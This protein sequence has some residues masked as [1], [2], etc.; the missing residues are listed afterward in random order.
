M[1]QIIFG[2]SG[3]SRTDKLISMIGDRVGSRRCLMIVPDQYTVTTERLLLEKLGAQSSLWAE[4]VG[5]GRL[6]DFVF[7]R[8]GGRDM[9]HL[10]E[11]GARILLSGVLGAVN[12]DLIYY[13]EMAKR[14]GFVEEMLSQIRELAANKVS[15]DKLHAAAADLADVNL[16]AKLNDLA[17]ISEAYRAAAVQSVRGYEFALDGAVE[18][19][20]ADNI[21]LQYDIFIDHFKRFTAQEYEMLEVMI[22]GGSYVVAG[23]TGEND[24]RCKS[25]LDVFYLPYKTA[26][27]LKEIAHGCGQ[28]IS[29]DISVP[30]LGI[31]CEDIATFEKELFADVV[32][33]LEKTAEHIKIV[34]AK[35]EY[36]ELEFI[37]SEIK[38]LAATNGYRWRDFAVVTRHSRMT[39]GL[40]E[41]AFNRYDIPVQLDTKVKLSTLPLMT[42]ILSAFDSVRSG[43]TYQNVFRYLKTGL[44]GLLSYQVDALEKYCYAWKIRGSAW[45]RP[46]TLHPDG[47]NATPTRRSKA[48][49]RLLNMW[50]NRFIAPLQDFEKQ[51]KKGGATDISKAVY[52]LLI[53][54]K[55]TSRLEEVS[56]LMPPDK[57][58]LYSQV[59]D[60][61]M[62]ILDDMTEMAGAAVMPERY[63]ELLM[64]AG[65]HT[66]IGLI[67]AT[68]DQVL[69]SEAERVI[70]ASV[71]CTFVAGFVS[72][73][74]PAVQGQNSLLTI[75][76][77][78]EL[79]TQNLKLS[80]VALAVEPEERYLAYNALTSATKLLYITMPE[81]TLAGEA[82]H[83]SIYLSPILKILPKN[84]IQNA[85]K[86]LDE[87]GPACE[88][89]LVEMLLCGGG[90]PKGSA[91]PE[92]KIAENFEAL[93]SKT[94][95]MQQIPNASK[96]YDGKSKL[97]A[98]SG[99]KYAKCNFSYFCSNGLR[100]QPTTQN[101]FGPMQI[102]T[103]I[104]YVLEQF[105][106]RVPKEGRGT[107]SK[108]DMGTVIE[109][110]ISNYM[111]EY[112]SKDE[113]ESARFTYLFGRLY[114]IVENYM[115]I[116]QDELKNSEFE[117]LNFELNVG[118]DIPPI[119]YYDDSGKEIVI[120]GVID[121]VDGY[122]KD[123]KLYLRIVDYKTG[124]KKIN[125]SELYQGIGL[126]MFLYLAA[127]LKEGE[128]FY[129]EPVYPAGVVYVPVRLDVI[130]GTSRNISDEELQKLRK[131]EIEKNALLINDEEI[132][133]AM[134]K[135]GKFL[136]LPVSTD[137]NGN[138]KL[139][140]ASAAS[141]EQLMQLADFAGR[142]LQDTAGKI[143]EGYV[144]VNPQT[145]STDK[146]DACYFCDMRPVCK[147]EGKGIKMPTVSKDEFWQKIGGNQNG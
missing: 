129:G 81:S 32:I 76:E 69:I 60:A 20:T 97:S 31:F 142:V 1:L 51:I 120:K 23:L 85:L 63:S 83:K 109:S 40:M 36:E 50:R 125:Y 88:A 140:D 122:K 9:R 87:Q 38:R 29:P 59:W 100:L 14:P 112:I 48:L 144:A 70:G 47:Y 71:K 39:S 82:V 67:P 126:Q 73:E 115:D 123:D 113:E 132:L 103:F 5:F 4:V 128:K 12:S 92:A 65:E 138:I 11:G 121:R 13:R 75:K 145:N 116:L 98:T 37:A 44:A 93:V 117:P 10:S 101:E 143:S 66:K 104:H 146:I 84:E 45:K 34:K 134:D 30:A 68:R 21:F 33:P 64:L 118:T 106:I 17:L 56:K 102:G 80:P 141:T 96:L 114:K 3:S 6:P 46:F 107:L 58:Q 22:S 74:F 105:F 86:I 124:E 111:E 131:K 41:A 72:G 28:D 35:T 61:V 7:Q 127:I 43:Y 62:D 110:I 139:Q 90:L 78:Q 19:C 108:A 2:R 133:S 77:R 147:Y 79:E 95:T 94:R 42:M 136:T 130:K 54:L 26:E 91:R 8:L 53:S 89:K 16:A 27:K 55:I 15:G 119:V 135:S 99:E 52:N 137:K 57:K 24:R 49:L 25:E 18:L